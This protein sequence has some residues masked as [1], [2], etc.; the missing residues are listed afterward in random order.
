MTCATTSPPF[1]SI[2]HHGDGGNSENRC[3]AQVALSQNRNCEHRHPSAE[4][5][6]PSAGPVN[7]FKVMAHSTLDG[8]PNPVPRIVATEKGT[9]KR[10]SLGTHHILPA[11]SLRQSPGMCA[12][13]RSSQESIQ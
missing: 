12:G 7:R 1:A 9:R 4:R 10:M 5:R 13:I 2:L 6:V 11:T 8:I 3:K